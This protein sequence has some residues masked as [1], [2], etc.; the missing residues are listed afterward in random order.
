MLP[1]KH[2]VGLKTKKGG[3]KQNEKNTDISPGP[4][5]GGD[6]DPDVFLCGKRQRHA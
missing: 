4:P 2:L 1:Q 5:D 6:H 3:T